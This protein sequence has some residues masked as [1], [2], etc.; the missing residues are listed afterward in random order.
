MLIHSE[1]STLLSATSSAR[2]VQA[3]LAKAPAAPLQRGELSL[4]ELPAD[5]VEIEVEACG[6]CH[7]DVS[8]WRNAW[9]RGGFPL[10][11]GHEV[12]GRVVARGA[13]VPALYPGQRVGVGWYRRSCMACQACRRGDLQHCE[14]LQRL[15]TDGHGGL[16]E[17]I[18]CHWAWAF[19]I[20]AALSPQRAGSLFCAGI[21]AFAPISR[22]AHATHRAAVVGVGG[23]GHLAIRFL[24]AFGCE[25][26]AIVR[27]QAQARDALALGAHQ[28]VS[29]AAV[30]HGSVP[31]QAVDLMLITTGAKLPWP[32][33]TSLLAPQAR[34]HLLAMQCEA[35][36][37]APA[38]L[39]PQAIT[40]SSSPLGRPDEVTAMLSFCVRHD[41]QPI[42]ECMPMHEANSAL[43]RLESGDVRYRIMLLPDF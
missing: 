18:R 28:A 32:A 22:Y 5:E 36:P 12:V 43:R 1:P 6:L 4:S 37:I 8:M 3:W 21:T 16:A 10:V 11:L 29:L 15:L 25:V 24:R 27:D 30:E 34:L 23:L 14:L 42:V 33:L 9:G 13:Q 35:L 2:R 17:R 7:S 39:I 38:A 40:I 20:P 26:L 19:P 41:I 31:R